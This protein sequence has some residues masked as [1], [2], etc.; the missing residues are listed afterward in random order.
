MVIAI[1]KNYLSVALILE[2][3]LSITI[4]LILKKLNKK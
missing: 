4:W 3:Y 2:K 1:L